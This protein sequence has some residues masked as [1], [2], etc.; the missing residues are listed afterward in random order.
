M[1]S[2]NIICEFGKKISF[3]NKTKHV[4]KRVLNEE[5]IEPKVTYDSIK[6]KECIT[7]NKIISKTNWSK[8]EKTL[9][10]NERYSN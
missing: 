2:I 1:L 10:H 9:I 8:H 3:S 6:Y 7:C 5:K 4:C